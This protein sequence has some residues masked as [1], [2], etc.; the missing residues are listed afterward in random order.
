[1]TAV[2]TQNSRRVFLKHTLIA[3][4]GVYT[5]A[6]NTK[7]YASWSDN[8]FD[9]QNLAELLD[10]LAEGGAAELSEQIQLTVPALVEN[11]AIVPVSVFAD[12]DD[13]ESIAILVE[14]NVNPLAG[15]YQFGERVAAKI[16][17]RVRLEQDSTITA[18][19]KAGGKHYLNSADVALKSFFCKPIKQ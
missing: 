10:G 16:S 8:L 9:Q 18:L 12:I 5:L 7:V 19:V 15:R 17:T 11:P 2:D 13:V 4:C 6:S 1:M 3:S 14:S